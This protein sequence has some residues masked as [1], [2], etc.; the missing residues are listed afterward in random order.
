MCFLT[1]CFLLRKH[2]SPLGTEVTLPACQLFFKRGLFSITSFSRQREL[3]PL[4]SRRSAGAGGN[5]GTG[6]D[7]CLEQGLTAAAGK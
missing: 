6:S 1:S 4:C 3:V 2:S 5:G 7:L